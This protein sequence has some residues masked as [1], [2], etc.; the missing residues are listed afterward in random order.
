MAAFANQGKL[1]LAFFF[2]GI[3][4]CRVSHN[5]SR[6]RFARGIDVTTSSCMF[7]VSWAYGI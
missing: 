2:R 6:V 7:L 4:D 3:H 5:V 1:I